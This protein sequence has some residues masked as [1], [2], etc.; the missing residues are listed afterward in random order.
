MSADT[1]RASP[2]RFSFTRNGDNAR[3]G[4][5]VSLI[6][7]AVGAILAFAVHQNSG[8]AVNVHVVGWILMG[9]GLV[10]LLLALAWWDRFGPGAW[11]WGRPYDDAPPGPRYRRGYAR[12]R[13]VVEDDVPPPADPYDAP[14]P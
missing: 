8:A 3:V 5:P 12:R 10:G 2:A 13:T 9:V 1:T 4:L 11:G 6:L 7:I 14:P